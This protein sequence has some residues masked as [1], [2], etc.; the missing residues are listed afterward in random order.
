MKSVEYGCTMYKYK[1][2]TFLSIPKGYKC[3]SSVMED[4][5]KVGILKKK[6]KLIDYFLILWI[7]SVIF[8]YT[9]LARE[10][11]I[12]QVP[13]V[14]YVTEN[15]LNVDVNNPKENPYPVLLKVKTMDGGVLYSGTLN[16]G[17]SLG[18]IEVNT[19]QQSYIIEYSVKW[20]GI[21]DISREYTVVNHSYKED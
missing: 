11:Q 2:K 15:L 20:N 10:K 8:C 16:P 1:K 5:K 7:I 19:K 13:N 4:G 14:V 18:A 17:E 9:Q 3:V 21:L 12:V 6:S